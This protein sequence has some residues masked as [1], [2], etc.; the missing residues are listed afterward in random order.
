MIE[1][2]L[3]AGNPVP[4]IQPFLI[5]EFTDITTPR[6]WHID[7]AG[8]INLYLEDAGRILE[9]FNSIPIESR[10]K[11]GL[12]YSLG[13]NVNWMS[14]ATPLLRDMLHTL[15]IHYLHVER[16]SIYEGSAGPSHILRNG[17]IFQRMGLDFPVR[18]GTNFPK[19][20]DISTFIER[21]R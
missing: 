11:Q 6:D 10:S 1:L 20:T 9:V 18:P 4:F 14:L 19:H 15:A 16:V 17:A 8:K 7:V 5:F 13:E 12:P 3:D 2:K 21:L